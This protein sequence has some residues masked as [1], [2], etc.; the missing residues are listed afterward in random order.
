LNQENIR[1]FFF[2]IILFFPAGAF[3]FALM[4]RPRLTSQFGQGSRKIKAAFAL[5]TQS[6]QNLTA[7]G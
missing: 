4:Q 5:C 3:I 6:L 7:G 2:I 1:P